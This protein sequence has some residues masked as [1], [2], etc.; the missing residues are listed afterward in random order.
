MFTYKI[1]IEGFIIILHIK[2]RLV[3]II[4][5]TLPTFKTELC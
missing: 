5:H 4:I 3:V 2:L 1:I